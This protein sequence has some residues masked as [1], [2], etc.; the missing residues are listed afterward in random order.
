MENIKNL[1]VGYENLKEYYVEL[2]EKKNNDIETWLKLYSDVS[3]LEYRSKDTELYY[4]I[5]SLSRLIMDKIIR[6]SKRWKNM[7][8]SFKEFLEDNNITTITKSAIE[9]YITYMYY[10]L[11]DELESPEEISSV[12]NNIRKKLYSIYNIK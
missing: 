8:N 6:I 10:E 4:N 9:D 7:L 11:Y 3:V 12:E 1:M 5:Q 2:L